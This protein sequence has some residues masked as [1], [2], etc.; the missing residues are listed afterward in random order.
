MPLLNSRVACRASGRHIADPVGPIIAKC[1]VLMTPA[2]AAAERCHR[3]YSGPDALALPARE[4]R[5]SDV[6]SAPTAGLALRSERS[7]RGRG[8]VAI[9]GRGQKATPW[10]ILFESD[11]SLSRGPTHRRL[12]LA[13]Y[14][15]IPMNCLVCGSQ[16][17]LAMVEPHDE[18]RMAGFE[19]RTFQ[20][21]RCGDRERRFVFDPRPSLDPSSIAPSM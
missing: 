3:S 21:E 5:G 10:N 1:R 15:R 6:H 16:M 4:S 14:G 13:R 12:A 11:L 17:R 2:L 20:C 9:W 18:V 19:Y 7:G 8:G